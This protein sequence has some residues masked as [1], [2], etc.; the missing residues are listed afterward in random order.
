MKSQLINLTNRVVSILCEDGKLLEL[1]P[2]NTAKLKNKDKRLTPIETE[3]NDC[4]YKVRVVQSIEQKVLDLPD[5][6]E[7]VYYIV[8]R[9]IAEV[10][11]NKRNDLYICGNFTKDFESKIEYYTS[12]RKL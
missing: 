2:Q 5:E 10:L 8:N 3:Y 1:Q 11:K 6:K 12:L 7:G 4:I 9:S